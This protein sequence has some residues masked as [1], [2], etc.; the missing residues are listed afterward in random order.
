MRSRPAWSTK[1]SRTARVP[2]WIDYTR[3]MRSGTIRRCGLVGVGVALLEEGDH[4][5]GGR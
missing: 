2:Q 3:P 5:G 4:C 1:S